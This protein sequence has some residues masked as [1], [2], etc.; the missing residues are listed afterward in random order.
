MSLTNVEMP[1]SPINYEKL[2]D[3]PKLDLKCFKGLG[4][5]PNTSLPRL[6]LKLSIGN[7]AAVSE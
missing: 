3:Y 7:F 1:P 5:F 6:D 2:A 4:I